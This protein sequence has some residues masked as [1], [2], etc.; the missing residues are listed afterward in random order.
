M[1]KRY[2]EDS[3]Y[4]VR[5]ECRDGVWYAVVSATV[6]V[7]PGESTEDVERDVFNEAVRAAHVA[8]ADLQRYGTLAAAA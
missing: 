1:T 5:F 4:T 8:A 6:I 3:P 7:A 2:D